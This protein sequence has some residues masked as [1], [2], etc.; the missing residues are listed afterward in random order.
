MIMIKIINFIIVI[1]VNF[2]ILLYITQTK[3]V[4]LEN[5][6]FTKIAIAI[7]IY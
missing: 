3:L 2:W 7:Y 4:K 1:K 5:T 6:H